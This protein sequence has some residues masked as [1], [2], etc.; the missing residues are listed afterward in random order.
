MLNTHSYTVGDMPPKKL[1]HSFKH[2]ERR[3]IA[4]T[5]MAKQLMELNESI[6]ILLQ[7]S[8]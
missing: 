6:T 7:I 3:S 5:E 4:N 8:H 2:F 1:R